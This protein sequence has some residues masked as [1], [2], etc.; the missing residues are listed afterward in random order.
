MI[1][2]VILILIGALILYISI[3]YYCEVGWKIPK[4]FIWLSEFIIGGIIFDFGIMSGIYIL[5][6]LN[7]WE[8]YTI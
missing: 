5:L 7:F 3:R 1:I 2:S 4:V 6:G 8:I